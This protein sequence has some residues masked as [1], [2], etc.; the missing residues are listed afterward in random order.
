[1]SPAPRAVTASLPLSQGWGAGVA[2]PLAPRVPRRGGETAFTALS[3]SQACIAGVAVPCEPMKG[4]VMLACLPPGHGEAA[5]PAAGV[6][7]PAAP[8]SQRRVKG[9]LTPSCPPAPPRPAASA[10]NATTST[11]RYPDIPTL[12]SRPD[13]HAACPGLCSSLPMDI[14]CQSG[15]PGATSISA[16]QGRG[17]APLPGCPACALG[18]RVWD[19][20]PPALSFMPCSASSRACA[21]EI[22]GRS[23]RHKLKCKDLY[24]VPRSQLTPRS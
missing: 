18:W 21:A 13:P 11:P 3:L 19:G 4:A 15:C 7:P 12:A 6:A 22:A 23:K 20:A 2:M 17:A 14:C 1:M 10:C 5:D 8:P 16:S 9:L 24:L